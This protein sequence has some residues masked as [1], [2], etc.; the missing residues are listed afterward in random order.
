MP[1]KARPRAAHE[2]DELDE[3]QLATCIRQAPACPA[4]R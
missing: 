2:E 1:R 3:A 4:G